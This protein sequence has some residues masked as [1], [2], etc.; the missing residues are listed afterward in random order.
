[1]SS[2]SDH[3]AAHGSGR[4]RCHYCQLAVDGRFFTRWAVTRDTEILCCANC[5]DDAMILHEDP[6]PMPNGAP[7]RHRRTPTRAGHAGYRPRPAAAHAPGGC[8]GVGSPRDRGIAVANGR[9]SSERTSR[10]HQ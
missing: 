1:M 9:R 8:G 4:E 10:S 5:W 7:A 3:A 2:E 6:R